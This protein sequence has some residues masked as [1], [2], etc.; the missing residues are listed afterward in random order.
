MLAHVDLQALASA[1][2]GVLQ[3]RNA[4]VTGVAIDSR[5][6]SDGNLFV[7]LRGE[8]ADGHDFVE[9]A[10]N[11]GAVGAMVDHALPVLA[12]GGVAQIIVDNCEQAL[13]Q[14]ASE[15]RQHFAGKVIGI[16][17]SAGKTSCKNLLASVLAQ[18]G[19][20]HA[21]T[22]N[23]NNELGLPLTVLA[24]EDRHRY[25]VL[26]MGAAKHGDI[27]YL[28]EI[29][30]PQIALVTNVGEA[31]LAGFGSL[32]VTAATKGEI[33]QALP[34]DGIAVINNDDIF[35][36]FWRGQLN[37]RPV[38]GF[39]LDDDGAD[40][41]ASA[42]ETTHCGAQFTLHIAANENGR[43]A[44]SA[45][46]AMAL[47]GLENIRNALAAAAVALALDTPLR[48]I[49]TGLQAACPEPRR[50][51]RKNGV[52][53]LTII[54]DSY[55]ANPRSMRAALDVLAALPGRS[56]A[57]LG[58]MGELG[59][60]AAQLHADVGRYAAHVGIDALF[61]I[62]EFAKDVAS[63]FAGDA[64]VCASLEAMYDCLRAAEAHGANVLFKASRF[65]G[66]D[67]LV[68]RLLCTDDQ[69]QLAGEDAC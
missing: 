68:D 45:N 38:L 66:M 56:V 21:T 4:S 58:D 11:N 19:E 44:Q 5:Q 3:G 16:T 7:A 12:A 59:D 9:A 37:D 60:G 67:R 57:V 63:E 13:G 1:C 48:K 35:A 15:M 62:G 24:L 20:V 8:H 22:G 23:L 33:Y 2:G 69:D 46:V 42:I 40:V 51:Q 49:V 28:S 25:A 30:Q 39:A 50:L 65:V 53:G 55:N 47:L 36:D 34:S 29:A 32:Q 18:C 52:N 17:G 26:E 64:T 14:I 61:L 31:H 10:A 6:I 41:Y 27:R 43:K 54:D